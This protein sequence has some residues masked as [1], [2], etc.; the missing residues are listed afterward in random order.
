M[1]ITSLFSTLF[2]ALFVFVAGA[3]AASQIKVTGSTTVLP[4]MQKAAEDYMAANPGTEIVIS[5][6]GSGSGIKSLI[7]G[8]CTIAMASRDIKSNEVALAQKNGVEPN[9]VAVAIDALIP[10][11][12]PKNPVKAISSADL[13]AIYMGKIKNW[14]ELGGN[15]APIVVI[16]RDTS[17]GTYETW[18]EKIMKKQR[19]MPAALLQ[20]SNGAIVQTVAGNPNAIGYI[21]FGYLND[22]VKQI[23][24]DNVVASQTSAL[25]GSW[26]IAREL[27]V[28]TNGKGDKE[29]QAF[30]AYL[31]DPKKGQK[32]VA[33]I[34]FIP[35]SSKK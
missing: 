5:G 25:D 23:D 26:K 11:V 2:L 8:L 10:V 15:D 20:A 28:F 22:D 21:G 27:Y 1:K 7:D 34:G 24:V 6:G 14:K 31:L 33:E 35:L 18:F 9:R 16:S 13:Q 17:S 19:V 30:I 4:I 3:N 29:T 12:N 32:A